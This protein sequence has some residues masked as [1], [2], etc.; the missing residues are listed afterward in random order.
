MR[1][2]RTEKELV[3]E[4]QALQGRLRE[5]EERLALKKDALQKN[6]NQGTGPPTIS[7]T[8]DQET[9]WLLDA[10]S[11]FALLVDTQGLIVNANH[12]IAEKFKTSCDDLIGRCVYEFLPP[13]MSVRHKAVCMYVA[14]SKLP[15]QYEEITVDGKIY[16]TRIYPIMTEA[17]EVSRLG[18]FTTDVTGR[19]R[20]KQE[21]YRLA[22]ALEQ[23][24]EAI[25]ITDEN[26]TIDYV[27]HA[28]SQ[29]TGYTADEAIGRDLESL[30]VGSK[31]RESLREIAETVTQGNT[32]A[33]RTVNTRKNGEPFECEG[34]VSQ[35]TGEDNNLFGY[36]HVW[37][38]VTPVK[39]L[40]K[41]LRQSQ[42]MEAIATLAGGIAHDFNN[43]LGPIILHAEL[44]LSML[45][46]DSPER[47]SFLQI[48]TAAER[49]KTLVDQILNLSRK[50]E[51]DEPQPFQLRSLIKE[52]VKLLRPTLPATIKISIDRETSEDF[53]LADPTQIHQVIMN[54]C[55]NAAHAMREKGGE[56]SLKLRDYNK[57]HK[58]SGGF[59]SALPGAYLLLSVCDTGHGITPDIMERIFEPFFTSGK[60][61]LGTGLGLTVVERIVT[62]LGGDICVESEPDK[63]STFH[64]IFPKSPL[65]PDISP[66]SAQRLASL[67][68]GSERILLVDDEKSIIDTGKIILERLGYSVVATSSSKRAL[69]LFKN[70]PG[71]FDLVLSDVTMPDLTGIDLARHIMSIRSEV[72]II[73][74]SGYS[75]AISSKISKHIGIRQFMT[76]PFHMDT[77]AKC[78]RRVLDEEPGENNAG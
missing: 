77:L 23:A 43:I 26:F 58:N 38:D 46:G 44:G 13:D 60:Q 52:C 74:C 32:W 45:P 53:I 34:T 5:L 78:I 17:G 18:V 41:Q 63:G 19:R 73:L 67:P 11:D 24:A 22:S 39:E 62:R 7:F 35:I 55:T 6:D 25:I 69:R 49:A 29:M 76:K 51:D 16:K 33:G 42:K 40:E 4:I 66:S 68:T 21:K 30:Y 50:H 31:Q 64:I 8:P 10:S 70:D 56:L 2:G 28:F 57:P 36:V 72:P 15:F 20:V 27:N 37:R 75:D 61:G 65:A 48:L 59:P 54:L 1:S 9:D 47:L 14:Q 12:R 71:G 3:G